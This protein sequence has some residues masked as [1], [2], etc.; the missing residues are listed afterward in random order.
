MW[1]L[2][3]RLFCLVDDLTFASPPMNNRQ[4]TSRGDSLLLLCFR[5][6]VAV[7]A[8]D[9]VADDVVAAVVVVAGLVSNSSHSAVAGLLAWDTCVASKFVRVL[10]AAKRKRKR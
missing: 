6:A 5:V 9:V 2:R 4:I 1:V 8:D 10:F 3:H 7:D